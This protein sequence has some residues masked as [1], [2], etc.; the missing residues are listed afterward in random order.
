M[1][2]RR[3]HAGKSARIMMDYS[4]PGSHE[5]AMDCTLAAQAK[6]AIDA[7]CLSAEEMTCWQAN[8]KGGG[9]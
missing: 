2:N 3:Y 4:L 9:R 7:A 5:A 1:K 8:R 6:M